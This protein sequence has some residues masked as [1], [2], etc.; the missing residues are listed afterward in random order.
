MRRIKV[1]LVCVVFLMGGCKTLHV[2]GH[3][4]TATAVVA[5][6]AYLNHHYNG[7]HYGQASGVAGVGYQVRNSTGVAWWDAYRRL[8]G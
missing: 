8:G 4:A 2:L 5:G 7:H 6:A 1:L 3:V